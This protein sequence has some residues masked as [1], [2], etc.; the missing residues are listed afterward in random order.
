MKKEVILLVL[1]FCVSFVFAKPEIVMNKEFQPGETLF[2]IMRGD[3]STAISLD[4]VEFYQAR[5]KIF[6]E[7]NLIYSNGSYYL[8][9]YMNNAGNYTLKINKILYNDGGIKEMSVEENIS[10]AD[11]FLDGNMT[12]KILSIKPGFVYGSGIKQI[13]LENKGNSEI[14]IEY[15]YNDAAD[16]FILNAGEVRKVEI[17]VL[18]GLSHLNISSYSQFSIPIIS[19]YVSNFTQN[20]SVEDDDL[21]TDPIYLNVYFNVNGN[22]EE[23]VRLMNFAE[24]NITSISAVSNLS[25]F[26]TVNL[27]FLGAKEE[28][29]ISLIFS[30][31]REGYFKDM[32]LI[33]YLIDKESKSISIPVEIYVLAENQSVETFSVDDNTC[34]ESS[35]FLCLSNEYCDGDTMFA[36]DGYCCLGVCKVYEAPGSGGGS[37]SWIIGLLILVVLGVGGYFAYRKYKKTVPKKPNE[38]VKLKTDEYQKRISGGISRS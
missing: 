18:P 5:K 37:Y 9:A 34:S 29:N 12:T 4:D 2:A 6:V 17:N 25:L 3:F 28:S 14:N 15:K 16:K 13:N 19:S 30:S 21:K 24:K 11:K 27:D 33:S 8:Y 20:V 36:S 22:K 38:M 26:D 35:G 10:V 1:L 32:V 23:T 31:E 7:D